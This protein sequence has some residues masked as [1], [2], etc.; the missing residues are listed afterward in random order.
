M[1]AL[2]RV[3][4][5]LTILAAAACNDAT[6]PTASNASPGVELGRKH[7][8][9]PPPAG[10][11]PTYVDPSNAYSMAHAIN[12]NG[13]VTGWTQP[14]AT[15]PSGRAPMAWLAGTDPSFALAPGVG[16]EGLSILDGDPATVVSDEGGL[17]SASSNG[18]SSYLGSVTPP[19]GA[20]AFT[21]LHMNASGELAGSLASGGTSSAFY[22]SSSSAT[23]HALPGVTGA[24]SVWATGI[25]GSG[26]VVGYS[27]VSSGRNGSATV[28]LLW[29]RSSPSS[30]PDV[31]QALPIPQGLSDAEPLAINAHDV[32]AGF[33][34]DKHGHRVPTAWTP[35]AFD[36]SGQPTAFAVETL[37]TLGCG[38]GEVW[39]LDDEQPPALVGNSTGSSPSALP[40]GALW[41]G[42]PGN[43]TV[44]ELSPADGYD[45]ADPRAVV[46]GAAGAVRVVGGIRSATVQG[47]PWKAAV[48]DVSP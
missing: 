35:T 5:V 21:E 23:A 28:P 45:Y 2:P 36:G 32:I 19:P 9:P 44:T 39:G 4:L 40:H 31:V 25:N 18:T 34:L 30:A 41:R 3:A 43:W 48:W 22:W 27:V 1:S 15:D 33:L 38:C 17:W 26:V 6:L 8:P 16:T 12:A 47:S 10:L 29:T 11:T 46:P 14:V 20:G 7:S 13:L 24:T 37:P 42:G